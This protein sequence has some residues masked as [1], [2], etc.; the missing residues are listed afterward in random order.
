MSE[1]QVNRQ[2]VFRWVTEVQRALEDDRLSLDFQR[3]FDARTPHCQHRLRFEL[4]LRMRTEDGE[5][6]HP[7]QFL[8]ALERFNLA[9]QLDRWVVANLLLWL[10]RHSSVLDRIEQCS[11]NL[12]APSLEDPAFCAFLTR[13]LDEA[14]ALAGKICFEIKESAAQA[15]P[16]ALAR[17]VALLSERG[18]GFALDEFGRGW[19]S[20][21]RLKHLPIA[22]LKIG[23]D[24]VDGILRDQVDRTIVKAINEVGHAM[25]REV[26][27]AQVESEDALQ[28][29]TELG[30]DFVQGYYLDLPQPFAPLRLH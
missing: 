8:P 6:V 18:C 29:L 22:Q 17:F 9:A 24:L 25:G 30:V 14:P 28:A 21:T 15:N 7:G 13:R 10:Q 23:G 11:V 27:A 16:D 26:V 4:L 3:I 19:Q 1:L 2:D 20:F 12:C 5:A